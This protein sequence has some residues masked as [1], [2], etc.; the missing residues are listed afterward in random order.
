MAQITLEGAL[1]TARTQFGITIDQMGRM[2]RELSNREMT[3]IVTGLIVSFLLYQL[4][5]NL[6][7]H[8]LARFPGPF[9]ARTSLVSEI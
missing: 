4:I 5:Y 2:Y 6:Y 8:P 7:F 1:T 9:W 3:T